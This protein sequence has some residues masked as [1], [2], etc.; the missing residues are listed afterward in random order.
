[1]GIRVE[2]TR[3]MIHHQ[4]IDFVVESNDIE[5][6]GS[7]SEVDLRAHED[8]LE[9]EGRPLTVTDLC[10]F[11]YQ[12]TTGR[13]RL[14]MR[15]GM[16]NVTVGNHTPPP[17]GPAIRDSLELILHQVAASDRTAGAYELHRVFEKLHPFTDGNGRVGRALWLRMMGGIEKVPLGF[18]HT[19][20]YQSLR[21]SR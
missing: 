4:L 14:R 19:W 12:V 21:A 9:V 20:Y 5:D 1:V 10:A 3:L 13:G 6:I 11:V 17:G 16:A 15:P 8:L 7:T 2:E 18:L